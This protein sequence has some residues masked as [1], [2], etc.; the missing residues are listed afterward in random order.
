MAGSAKLK[1]GDLITLKGF[2][3]LS[4]Q[5]KPVGMVVGRTYDGYILVNWTNQTLADRFA[6]KHTISRHKLELLNDG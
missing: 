6:L 4:I 1:T 2:K 3:K 5:E